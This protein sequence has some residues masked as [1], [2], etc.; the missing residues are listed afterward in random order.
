MAVHAL[1]WSRLVMQIKN[2]WVKAQ[3]TVS[4]TIT[5]PL[6]LMSV[7]I[8]SD[9]LWSETYI[10]HTHINTHTCTHTHVH[11]HAR[12]AYTLQLLYLLAV[13]CGPPPETD[14]T[15]H[16]LNYNSTLEGS[17][18]TFWCTDIQLNTFISVCHKNASWIPDPVSQCATLQLGTH[19]YHVY[20]NKIHD[21]ISTKNWHSGTFS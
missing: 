13:S 2:Y 16:Y 8:Y 3:R 21:L 1:I 9:I 17:T 19:A 15:V 12:N 5:M 10:T 14:K 4:L 6:W 7:S 11:T 18:I 20:A